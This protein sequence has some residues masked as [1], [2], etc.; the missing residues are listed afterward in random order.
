MRAR[1]EPGPLEVSRE[2]RAALV[3]LHAFEAAVAQSVGTAHVEIAPVLSLEAVETLEEHFR[4]N[5]PDDALALFASGADALERFELGKVGGLTEDAWASGLSKAR[6]VLG[7]WGG[8][9]V[10]IPRR[11]DRGYALRVTFFDRADRTEGDSSTLAAWLDRVVDDRRDLFELEDDGWDERDDAEDAARRWNPTLARTVAPLPA[12]DAPKVRR[13]RHARFGEGR[14][15]R[16][17][18]MTEKLEVDFGA[19]GTRVVVANYLEEL[20]DGE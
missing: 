14:V 19:A 8:R 5:L 10:C 15:L 17:I 2:V 16:R 3:R 7:D 12:A 4:A 11:P 20:E 1:R 18:P 9:A 13:V 6:I